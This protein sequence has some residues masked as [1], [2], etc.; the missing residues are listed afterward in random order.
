M[1]TP[2]ALK[3]N[4][5]EARWEMTPE[6]GGGE[7]V[8]YRSAD[9]SRAVVAF[10]ETGKHTF[11]YPFDEFAFVLKGSAKVDVHGGEKFTLTAGDIL[12]VEEGTT[13]DFEMDDEFED[14]TM[15]VSDKPVSW[16]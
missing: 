15:L 12:Y 16:R 13:I 10:K 7:H 8:F 3:F 4:M 2:K 9:K 14:I 5:K 6:F 11:T 1:S